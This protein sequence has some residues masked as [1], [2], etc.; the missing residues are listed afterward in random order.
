MKI[1]KII[2]GPLATNCY[3]VASDKEVGIIDPGD[4]A[5]KIL[6]KIKKAKAKYIILTHY[7]FDHL[8]AAEKI[9]EETGAKILIHQAEKNF[10]N[11]PIDQFIKEN[12]KIKIG[13]E[14]LKVIHSPGHTKGSLC[15]LGKNE[16]FTGDLIFKNGYGRTDLAG[17]SSED[18]RNSLKKLSCLLKERMTIFPG[19][20]EKFKFKK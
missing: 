5:E 10:I 20:G 14:F 9:K 17:G 7:H 13:S 15:L 16:I 3:L 1:K 6:T 2:V 18:L 4:E 19:H 12:D 8:G 11:F